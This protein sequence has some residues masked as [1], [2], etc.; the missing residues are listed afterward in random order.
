[1]IWVNIFLIFIWSY[2]ICTDLRDKDGRWKIWVFISFI[3]IVD[4]CFSIYWILV[5][6][7][8]L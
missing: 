7:G 4:N 1:M 3:W 6:N 8:D 2:F 5:R